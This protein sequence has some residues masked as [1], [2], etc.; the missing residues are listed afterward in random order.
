MRVTEVFQR[1]MV[2][3]FTRAGFKIKPRIYMDPKGENML[4]N[5]MNRRTRPY[6]EYKRAALAC[7]E[8]NSVDTTKIKLRWSQYAGC[9][10]PCSPGFIVEGWSEFL[11]QKNTWMT[12]EEG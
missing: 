6:K 3:S 2:P 12:V 10:C 1:E 11:D 8:E 9:S 7:L 5:L 4:D